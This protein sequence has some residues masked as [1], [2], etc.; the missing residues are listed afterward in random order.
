[1]GVIFMVSPFS[2]EVRVVG[3]GLAGGPGPVW[4]LRLH[5]D[6]KFGQDFR[7][8]V[9]EHGGDLA[10]GLLALDNEGCVYDGQLCCLLLLYGRKRISPQQ[11]RIHHEGELP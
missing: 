5:G 2:L 3:R 9:P 6:L 11:F 8:L 10:Q 1:M 7:Y 4:G